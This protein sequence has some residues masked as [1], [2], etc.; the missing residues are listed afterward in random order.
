MDLTS[1]QVEVNTNDDQEDILTWEN[2][3][4]LVPGAQDTPQVESKEED[5]ISDVT[6]IYEDDEVEGSSDLTIDD[7]DSNSE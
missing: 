5:D 6:E 7:A 3:D 4:G 2:S 1:V